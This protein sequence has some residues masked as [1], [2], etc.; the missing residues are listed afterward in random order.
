[1]RSTAEG[2]PGRARA[3]GA[4]RG[5]FAVC[6]LLA[7]VSGAA[8]TESDAGH[9]QRLLGIMRHGFEPSAPREPV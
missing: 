3:A 9:A 5:D 6:D 7:L 1:M 2:L 4:V 8:M